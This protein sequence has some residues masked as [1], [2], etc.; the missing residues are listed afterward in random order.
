MYTVFVLFFIVMDSKT[1]LIV[2]NKYYIPCV[3]EKVDWFS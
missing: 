1:V 3:S 2:L